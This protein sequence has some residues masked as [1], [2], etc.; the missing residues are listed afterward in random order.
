[1]RSK[2]ERLV[3][4][5]GHNGSVSESS[6]DDLVNILPQVLKVKQNFLTS[7]AMIYSWWLIKDANSLW[8]L[9]LFSKKFICHL[10]P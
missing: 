9:R 8:Y 4:P 6:I 2:S 10:S 5:H 7:Q 1:M 3:F